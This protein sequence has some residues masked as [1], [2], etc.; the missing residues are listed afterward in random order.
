MTPIHRIPR[1]SPE[2]LTELID[3]EGPHD[4]GIRATLYDAADHDSKDDSLGIM[5]DWAM[6]LRD[7][8]G[9]DWGQCISTAMTLFYG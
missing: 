1:D 2:T 8:T 7:E 6:Q 4:K 5:L 9:R 3:L